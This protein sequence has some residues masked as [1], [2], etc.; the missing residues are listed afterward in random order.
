LGQ[1]YHVDPCIFLA[2]PFSEMQR[3]TYWTLRLIERQAI[4]GSIDNG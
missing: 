3:H 4:E 2:K 1:Y